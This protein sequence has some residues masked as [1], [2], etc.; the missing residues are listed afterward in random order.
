MRVASV[1][2]HQRS[3]GRLDAAVVLGSLREI[4]Q[5][6]MD[7]VI[8]SLFEPRM[9]QADMV[10]HEVEHQADAP[11]AQAL[12]QPRERGVATK[13]SMH[14]VLGDRET[15]SADVLVANARAT[16]VV[17]A[18]IAA[19]E[20]S[21]RAL[22]IKTLIERFK[23]DWREKGVTANIRERAQKL[24]AAAYFEKPYEA[25]DLLA[26]VDKILNAQPATA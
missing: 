8:G 9:V 19:F 5:R 17:Y 1:R 24:G 13:R 21:V 14:G 10:R 11:C 18:A 6:G 20:N 25:T 2:Q 26:A 22:V 12:S 4:L 15:R 7:E 3:G 16:A 23:E